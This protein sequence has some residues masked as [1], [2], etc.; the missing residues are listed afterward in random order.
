MYAGFMGAMKGG[1]HDATAGMLGYQATNVNGD[2]KATSFVRNGRT[3]TDIEVYD[4]MAK[5]KIAQADGQT[6][7]SQLIDI[8]ENQLNQQNVATK[9]WQ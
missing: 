7:I 8:L 3:F 1:E 6:I 5:V 2:A 4:I 9:T